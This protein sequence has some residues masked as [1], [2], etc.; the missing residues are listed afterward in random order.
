MLAMVAT[1]AALCAWCV[2]LRERANLQ[3]PIIVEAESMCDRPQLHFKRWG[4]RWLDL[5]GAE[6]YRRCI[7]GSETRLCFEDHKSKNA[8]TDTDAA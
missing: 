3:D 6:R 4:P 7:V 8:A 5:V 2:A 1:F